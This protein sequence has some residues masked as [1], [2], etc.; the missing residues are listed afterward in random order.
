MSRLVELQKL[1]QSLWLDNIE[2]RMLKN[3]EMAAMIKRGDIRG[4]TSNP[5]IFNKAISSS[6]DYDETLRPLAWSGLSAKEAFFELAVE[7]IQNTTDL[8]RPLYEETKGGDG[9]VSLEVSPDLAH[10]T[11]ITAAEAKLLWKKVN[12]PNLMVK[13]PATLEGLPAITE[14]IEAGININV[15]LIFSVKRYQAVIHAYM[16]GLERRLAKGLPIDK[17]ASVGSFFVSRIDSNVDARLKTVASKN[18]AAAGLSGKAAVACSRLVYQMAEEEFKTDRWLALEARGA[19]KQ[20]PLYASTSTKNPDYRDVIYIEELIGEGTVNTVPPQTLEAFRDHGEPR[21]LLTEKTEE[22]RQV[23]KDLAALGI[24]MDA[25]AEEL[26]REGVASFEDAFT[27]ML[28][29]I[30]DTSQPMREELGPLAKN[31]PTRVKELIEKDAVKRML[32]GDGSLWTSD[33]AGQEE[34]QKRVGW[35]Q[36]PERSRK[37]AAGLP[38]FVDGCLK[39]GFTHAVILGMGG[40][41]MAP[42]TFRHTF[43]VRDINGRKGLDLLILDST[44][45]RQVRSTADWSPLEKTLFIVASK[46][47]TTSEINAFLEY[48]WDKT[49]KA[50]GGKA[51]S[52]FI[53]ITDPGTALEKL[54][55][56]RVFRAVFS[57]DPEVGGRYSALTAF[58]LVPASLIGVD[59][60]RLLDFSQEMADQ[61]HLDTPGV[62]NPGLVLGAVLGEAFSQGR[63][64]LSLVADPELTAFGAWLEQLVA[65]SSG[66]QGKGIVPVD[67]EPF[68]NSILDAKDRLFVHFR[69][70]GARDAE[71]EQVRRMKQPILTFQ[72]NDEYEIAKEFF[73]WEAATSLAC[74]LMGV[75]S[76]DQPDVQDSKTRTA[77][78]IAA[79]N[80]NDR[81]EEGRP[82]WENKECSMYG[83]KLA[84]M[85]TAK[86]AREVVAEFLKLTRKGD[87]IAI[88]AYL[89]RNKATFAALTELRKKVMADT[90]NATTL[91][92]GPRF[93]HSTGQLHKG[94]ADNGLFLQIT[95]DEVSDLAIPGGKLTFGVLERAQALGD[96]EAL[97][98]R[99]RRVLRIHLKAI[100][101][102]ELL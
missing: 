5:S 83:K 80:Q 68:D 69:K 26:E 39:D 101:P 79:F 74:A 52:H 76:F 88:N 38:A 62:R 84:I 34:V 66:K 51:G 17:I 8:F 91:G 54:A 32:N 37:L 48:F 21:L 33:P 2:R 92:F 12:R 70:S 94:G 4:V 31:V 18:P 30:E 95:S 61:C 46:S 28:K 15:T 64:K 85:D 72:I 1:G 59:V 49:V 53:A 78:K 22:S 14:A 77:Q 99:G 60:N 65:E 36:A 45:P 3:G 9:Y 63:D 6:H 55:A 67:L 97:E 40:S 56:E 20:R 81:L 100:K 24:D 27:S 50:L 93:L 35:L 23:I 98:A 57:G 13:I 19:R 43:G 82:V 71:I 73:R 58:G 44:D 87:Y 41:S 47:G 7:D 29:T 10:N 11:A 75:N 42:E 25:V 96:F 102:A 90:G 16:A 86:I 89:P